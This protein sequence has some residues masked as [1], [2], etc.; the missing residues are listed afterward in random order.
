MQIDIICWQQMLFSE[1]KSNSL[2]LIYTT[3]L[4]KVGKLCIQI[5]SG[6][7]SKLQAF[8]FYELYD[9]VYRIIWKTEEEKDCTVMW[10][11]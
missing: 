6:L 3:K 4:N 11:N 9:I 1:Q 7:K 2:G 5:K 8:L 10:A